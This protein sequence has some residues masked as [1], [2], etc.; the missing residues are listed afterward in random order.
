MLCAGSGQKEDNSSSYLIVLSWGIRLMYTELLGHCLNHSKP[1]V[2]GNC[3]LLVHI[4]SSFKVAGCDI[5]VE[6]L[7]FEFDLEG[8][9]KVRYN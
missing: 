5:F 4:Y 2:R 7:T 9:M 6:N 1:E 3:L 8:F